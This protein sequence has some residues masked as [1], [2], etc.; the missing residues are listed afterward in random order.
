MESTH[1]PDYE[2]QLALVHHKIRATLRLLEVKELE[3]QINQLRRMLAQ[4]SQID[5]VTNRI[6]SVQKS[7]EIAILQIKAER[8]Q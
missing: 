4:G 5:E 2:T 8:K 1:L 6:E 3:V 7:I